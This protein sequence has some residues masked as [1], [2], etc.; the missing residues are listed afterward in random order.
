MAN[1]LTEEQKKE[2]RRKELAILKAQNEMLENSKKEVM[3]VDKYDELHK[4]NVIDEINNAQSEN[5]QKAKQIYNA[6]ENEV[7]N[8]SYSDAN[9]YYKRKYNE[10]LERKKL[11]DKQI[12]TK[13]LTDDEELDNAT[14]TY[15]QSISTIDDMSD[16]KFTE[17]I[18]YQG[19]LSKNEKT[20]K[21]AEKIEVKS[22]KVKYVED[23]NFD[24]TDIPDYVQYDVLPLPSDGQCYKNKKSRIPVGY[25]TASDEN[26][27]TSPNL[28]R[29]GKILDL[30]LKRKILDKTINPDELCKGDR[31]AIILWLRATGY[32]V[33]FPIKVHDP[34]IDADYETTVKLDKIKTK[35]F[36][37]TG[38]EN[39]WFD[40]TTSG[41]DKIKFKYLSRIEEMELQKKIKK[42]LENEKRYDNSSCIDVL[43]EN[44]GNDEG[45][46]SID[47]EKLLSY[48]G[49]V[50]KWND[51]AIDELSDDYEE[52]GS[53]MTDVMVAQ[54][55]S[56]N[57]NTD[58]D[59]IYGYVTNM[60]ARTAYEYRKYISDNEPGMDL[61][62]KVNRPKSLGGGSF[63][64]FLKVNAF[65][66]LSIS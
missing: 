64:T 47:K 38:D 9:D 62:I 22:P 51:K 31:D 11:T 59:Y 4:A 36:K 56:I 50:K 24:I 8:S 13:D 30:L 28:Y 23:N 32:G 60:R 1:T 34:E 20:K 15:G 44:I 40:Y 27:I 10:R 25:L 35:P 26:L 52:Y 53:Q 2:I 48:M 45:L 65:L 16:N 19:T 58:R 29:D 7:N 54:T 37:L 3:D 5:L 63:S 55:M 18:G 21:K 33:D 12:R 6:D 61:N 39:G 14:I 66:F 17:P 42:D 49:I 43:L 41:G 46:S 57:G